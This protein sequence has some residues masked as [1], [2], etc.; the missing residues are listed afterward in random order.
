MMTDR[1]SGRSVMKKTFAGTFLPLIACGAVSVAG[2][3]ELKPE[4]RALYDIYKELVEINTTD[5]V[6]DN[7]EAA[8]A[9]AARLVAAG[10]PQDDVRVLVHPGNA[11][12]GNLVARLRGDG[13]QKPLLLLAH[14]DVVEAHKEDWSAD[15]DPFKMIERDGYYYGR[16]T[17]D[18]KAMAAIF[19]ANLI[20]YRQE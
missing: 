13:T 19:V 7:T 12:K 2:A 15:L 4:Q 18:D 8:R 5:S 1:N 14:L 10:F 11:K 6:G 20:R 3:A 9:M 16:G 17:S